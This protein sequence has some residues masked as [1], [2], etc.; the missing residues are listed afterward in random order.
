MDSV[1]EIVVLIFIGFIAGA[2]NTI[3]GGGSLLT[4]PILIFLGL[5]PNIANGTNRI[6]ILFQNIF[7]TAGFKSKGV[8]TFPFSIYV[9]IS[10]LIGS[11]IGAQ[12]AVDIK[13]E[14]FNKILAAI[15]VVIVF[16]MVFKSKITTTSIVEKTAGKHLWI[17]VV[18]FFFV[19]IYGGFIQAGVGFI[20]LLI[21]SSVNNLSLV[22]SNAVK[23]T[24]VLIYT[25]SSV[26]I[27]AYNDKI[28][29]EMGL[30][31]AI[32][33]SIGG[34]FASRWSVN[35]GDGMVRKFL[36]VMVVVLAIKL[37]YF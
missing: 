5:P 10:A 8:L 36:I 24:V 30:I 22:K 9:G 15:M 6:A 7:T 18:L 27:F 25:I 12:I 28:D 35:R 13:G 23:V 34:W 37:W 16:Y 4:L 31:L 2:I 3:A 17:S 19:G 14:T 33:N 11:L 32:G 20:I 26:A 29:W 21:L 1:L